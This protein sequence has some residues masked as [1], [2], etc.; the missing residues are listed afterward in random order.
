MK[1]KNAFEFAWGG[2]L[3]ALIA[4]AVVAILFGA[5]GARA[6]CGFPVKMGTAPPVP[7][8]APHA[9]QQYGG[10]PNQPATIVGLWHVV[11]TATYTTSGPLPLAIVPPAQPFVFTQSFKTW[12]SDGTEFDNVFLPPGAGNICYGV[13]KDMG[14]R[15]V[16]V[17]HVGLM[18]GPDGSLA[19]IFW[20]EETDTVSADGKTYEGSFD[21]KLY[22]PTDIFGTGPVVQEIKGR[23]AA[24]RI[25]VD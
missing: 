16:K 12:H 5:S 20:E 2:R 11:W 8:L 7:S 24:T 22:D 3:G 21:Q 10:G 19:N 13:W 25:A 4:F 18:F 9:G 1:H 17:R 15:T 14:H 6:G 23:T